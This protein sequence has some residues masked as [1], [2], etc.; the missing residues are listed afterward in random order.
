M[1]RASSSPT[2]RAWSEE[3]STTRESC[4][5]STKGARPSRAQATMASL[6]M[7]AAVP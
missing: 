2:A 3:V 1:T 6:A 4:T 7:S 5:W